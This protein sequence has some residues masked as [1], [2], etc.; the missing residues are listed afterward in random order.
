MTKKEG[1]EYCM[2]LQIHLY[3][4]VLL[5]SGEIAYITRVYREECVYQANIRTAG[6]PIISTVLQKNIVK[7]YP[8]REAW[9]RNVG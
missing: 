4:K 6:G 8:L 5:N 9:S 7:V 1:E 3:D 2:R